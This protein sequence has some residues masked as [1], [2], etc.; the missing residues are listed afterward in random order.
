MLGGNVGQFGGGVEQHQGHRGGNEDSVSKRRVNT[1]QLSCISV[2][3]QAH[4]QTHSSELND[5]ENFH[6]FHL[7]ERTFHPYR[8]IIST[9]AELEGWIF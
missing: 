5:T 6:R 7:P 3:Y 2:Y 1:S 4:Q 9:W 8:V